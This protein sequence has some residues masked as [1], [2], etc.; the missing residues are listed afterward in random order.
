MLAR[1]GAL[2]AKSLTNVSV[3]IGNQRPRGAP[4][5]D[6]E[7]ASEASPDGPEQL[8]GN[9]YIFEVQGRVPSLFRVG[10]TE[11][12]K[13]RMREHGSSHADS[14][15]ARATRIRVCDER[16]VERCFNVFMRDKK[17]RSGKEV[18]RADYAT[19]KSTIMSCG[20]ISAAHAA[21]AASG[22]I[23]ADALAPRVVGNENARPKANTEPRL[24]GPRT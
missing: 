9:I 20:L 3:L 4:D 18:F 14:I 12:F 16:T 1:F 22:R 17:Y 11:V 7:P 6:S 8:M 10:S 2:A 21:A 23:D 19:I 15:E 13:R 5:P 24:S